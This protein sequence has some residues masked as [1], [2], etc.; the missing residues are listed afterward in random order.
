MTVFFIGSARLSSRISAICSSVRWYRF[1]GGPFP[2][3]GGR[4]GSFSPSNADEVDEVDDDE[5]EAGNGFV[6]GRGRSNGDAGAVVSEC[7]EGADGGG[8]STNVR[9]GSSS[10]II[11]F[12]DDNNGSRG[13][14]SA[15]CIGLFAYPRRM[16]EIGA[17]DSADFSPAA[18]M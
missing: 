4:L 6:K 3:T 16:N 17:V 15:L 2:I 1:S 9:P 14:G 12:V 11:A 8:R 10:L 13:L 5:N 7:G 18:F